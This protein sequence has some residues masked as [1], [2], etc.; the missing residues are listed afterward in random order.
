MLMVPVKVGDQM[1]GVIGFYMRSA[2]QVFSARD[3]TLGEAIGREAGVAIENARLFEA[4]KKRAEEAE[5][6]R[7]AS[8]AV[9]SALELENVL[10]Q[11]MTNLNKVVPYDSCAIFLQE[12]EN[13][14]IVAARGSLT[15]KKSL[16]I[17]IRPS[18][19]YRGRHSY[20]QSDYFLP[21]R[22][23]ICASRMGRFLS[24]AWLD[25]HPAICTRQSD[26]I[27]DHR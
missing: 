22:S 19:R 18:Q 7:E 1:I 3:I 5:T 24:C 9:T 12:N 14:R 26:W 2:D 15:C 21:T 6:L 20:W 13:L 25:G 10:E 11:I 17:P 16:G 8:N 23:K 27:S 4:A